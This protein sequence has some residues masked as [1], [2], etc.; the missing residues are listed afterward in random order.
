MKWPDELCPNCRKKL[1][2]KSVYC[3]G[4][5]LVLPNRVKQDAEA[6]RQAKLHR[7][8]RQEKVFLQEFD[9]KAFELVI[10]KLKGVEQ[11]TVS[12]LIP[13]L[14]SEGFFDRYLAAFNVPPNMKS[15]K[16]DSFARQRVIGL[17]KWWTENEVAFLGAQV[18]QGHPYLFYL[19]KNPHAVFDP[20]MPKKSIAQRSVNKV[21]RTLEAFQETP[22]NP[23]ETGEVSG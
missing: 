22:P 21:A 13:L 1:P 18:T 3:P 17:A 15:L 9:K 12:D 19:G 11:V 10:A 2:R 23:P 7:S 14:A 8:K 6:R 20:T 16:F 4:C 5:E